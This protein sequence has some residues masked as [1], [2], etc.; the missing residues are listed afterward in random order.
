MSKL[1]TRAFI[2]RLKEKAEK[3]KDKKGVSDE[4]AD[5]YKD[6]ILFIEDFYDHMDS[7]KWKEW[8]GG[9]VIIIGSIVIARAG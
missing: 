5:F 7:I 4:E 2:D 9:A 1:L 6:L 8:L 3:L